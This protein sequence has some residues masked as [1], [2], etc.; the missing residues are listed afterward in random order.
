MASSGALTTSNGYVKYRIDV[1]TG[2]GD[3]AGNFTPVTV[4]VFVYRTNTGYT[5][6]GTGTI[7]CKINGTTYSEGI[8]PSQKITNSGITLFSKTVNVPHGEDGKKNLRVTSW[9]SIPG[10]NLSSNEQGFNVSLTDIPRASTISSVDGDV[11]NSDIIVNISRASSEFTHQVWYKI[12]ESEWFDLGM[13]YTTSCTFKIEL[14]K[15]E[16]IINSDSDILRLC[17][18]TFRGTEQIGSDHYNY[19]YKIRVP[20]SVVPA[21][22]R[23]AVTETIA[24]INEKFGTFLQNVSRIKVVTDAAGA[25]GSTIDSYTVTVLDVSYLGKEIRTNTLSESGTIPVKVTVK[26]SRGRT[27]TK[28]QNITVTEYQAPTIY[29]FDVIRAAADGTE[30]L[31]GTYAAC[32]VA[33]HVSNVL[34]K[35]TKSYRIEYKEKHETTWNTMTS[36]S[37]YDYD[38]TIVSSA[39]VLSADS[40]YTIKLVVADYFSSTE[41]TF[42]LGTGSP[43]IDFK[44]NKKGVALAKVS[45]KDG[46]ENNM[47]SWHYKTSKFLGD[48]L[49]TGKTILRSFKFTDDWMGFYRD[50]AHAMSNENR[51]GFMGFE[52]GAYLSV[53]NEIGKRIRLR[54]MDENEVM[55]DGPT[56]RPATVKSN[57][58]G[59]GGPSAIWSIIY[60]GTGQISTSDKIKKT[61]IHIPDE[62]YMKLAENIDI[63]QYKFIDTDQKDGIGRT[64]FG[65][66][67]QDV[68][69]AMTDLGLSAK[70][71]A[72]FCKDNKHVTI[73]TDKKGEEITKVIEG[74]YD[75]ALRYDELAMLKIWY[76]EQIVKR[77]QEEL[78]TLK[79][80]VLILIK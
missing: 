18:R 8:T 61:D 79:E 5:T 48:L 35:N 47:D 37:A 10:A 75:Y 70:D 6:W 67:S 42:E 45:E 19:N 58:I 22:N 44:Y 15:C 60:C 16:Y 9:L 63:V 31:D 55:L 72:G 3:I 76:L 54:D 80:K 59:L 4:S 77:Q 51:N 23:I 66:I 56:F 21:I 64:H 33:F 71:F 78:N 12:G 40:E 49:A 41:V 68:E 34:S 14:D 53:K 69:K 65:A 20:K 1:T 32:E 50:H 26:D 28:M 46:F 43:P 25:K 27:A 2:K 17:V 57:Q 36:G 52:G 7:W 30:E 13:E 62:V 29:K 11:I 74:E 73:G 39:S 38:D 24:G